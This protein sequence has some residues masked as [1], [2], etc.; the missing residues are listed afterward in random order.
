MFAQYGPI[1]SDMEACL[2][3]AA[4]DIIK[5]VTARQNLPTAHSHPHPNI[6][7]TST[8]VSAVNIKEKSSLAAL[9]H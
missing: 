5:T 7:P 3:R 8:K 4:P 1:S 9:L 6:N 2:S